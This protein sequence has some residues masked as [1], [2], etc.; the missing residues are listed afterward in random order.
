MV[1]AWMKIL[2]HIWHNQTGEI[3]KTLPQIAR[4][5]GEGEDRTK[6]ILGYFLVENIADVTQK[7]GKITIVCRRAKKDAKLKEQNRLRQQRARAK[8]QGHTDVTHQK[9]NPSSSSSSSSSTSIKK[10]KEKFDTFRKKY[11]GTKRGLDTE[12]N[13]F[14]KKHKDWK[15]ILPILTS[16]L[17]Q[18][19]STREN[20]QGFV[21][22]WK[23]LATW[24][25]NRCWEE[26]S[27][28]DVNIGKT[29]DF[30]DQTKE[31]I[32]GYKKPQI[33]EKKVVEPEEAVF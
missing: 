7:Y 5:I 6:D 28:G 3:T 13:N 8:Q 29:E 33:T 2:C 24:I 26:E 15:V 23:N 9:V 19:I 25:N 32:E 4:I 21:P 30:S 18:Q 1:G 17:E 10:D 27:G 20:T 12:F 31:M 16:S 22:E 14:C 11:L